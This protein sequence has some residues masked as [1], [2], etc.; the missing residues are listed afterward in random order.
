[1]RLT[2]EAADSMVAPFANAV[3]ID[4]KSADGAKLSRELRTRMHDDRGPSDVHRMSQLKLEAPRLPSSVVHRA[5]LMTALGSVSPSRLILIT[6]PA[7][8]GKTTL[9][10]QWRDHLLEDGEHVGWL[11]L[12]ESDSD[13]RRFMIGVIQSLEAAGV[14]MGGLG[15]QAERGLTE[16]T[17]NGVIREIQAEMNRCGKP[18]CHPVRRP[19]THPG[20]TDAVLAFSQ[21]AAA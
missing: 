11:T 10:S 21:P 16:V 13:V 5:R 17:I 8:F 6:A 9:L 4:A 15:A 12:D 1:M 2:S 20:L 18:V 7:G 3:H 19:A 14:E